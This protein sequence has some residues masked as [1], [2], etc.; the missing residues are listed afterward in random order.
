MTLQAQ[1]AALKAELDAITAIAETVTVYDHVPEAITAPAIIIQPGDP[2]LT[3]EGQTYGSYK[4]TRLLS[5]IVE[6]DTNEVATDELERIAQA[7]IGDQ[8]VTELS[9]PF[10]LS[11][12]QVNYLTINATVTDTLTIGQT[13]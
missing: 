10:P 9:A 6:T 4:V 13:S 3:D 8:E 11:Y 12:N 7:I 1:R 5:I 2:Y